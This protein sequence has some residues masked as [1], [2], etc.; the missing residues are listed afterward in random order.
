MSR[1]TRAPLSACPAGGIGGPHLNLPQELGAPGL[2]FQTWETLNAGVRGFPFA[3]VY[4]PNSDVEATLDMGKLKASRIRAWWY[5]PRTGIGTLIGVMDGGMK[6]QFR[7][8]SHGPDWVLVLDDE[9]ARYSPPGL[10]RW[11]R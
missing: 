10:V 2:D 11:E 4:F 8:P 1:A 5:D 7:T 3:F 9:S 6:K